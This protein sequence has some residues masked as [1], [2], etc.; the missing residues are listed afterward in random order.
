MAKTCIF[1][2]P[3]LLLCFL[4]PSIGWA[5]PC[6][7][8]LYHLSGTVQYDCTAVTAELDGPLT[9]FSSC[10]PGPYAILPGS[11]YTFTFSPAIPTVR[12]N[13]STINN[14]IL[15]TEEVAFSVN[16]SFY[17]ITVPGVPLAGCGTPALIS[18]T[19]T[20]QACNG[21]LGA[22][23]DIVITEPISTLTIEDILISGAPAGVAVSVYFCCSSCN[24]YAGQML[25][26]PLDV[27]FGNPASLSSSFLPGLESNDILRYILFSDPS[28][29]LGS[30]LATS[31]TPNFPF[32]PATM[33]LGVPYYIAAIAGNNLGGNVDL[34]DPCLDISNAIPVTWHPRPTVEFAVVDPNV[35]AGACTTVTANLTG[36]PPFILTYTT[37]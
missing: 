6:L 16:G 17:P 19:G 9:G 25:D 14:N 27:C 30:I 3:F 28:D 36:T 34:N 21:C 29:T 26:D 1:R 4:A 23:G 2:Q 18:P 35:C 15:G 37:P 20:I 31:I 32:N 13:L 11:S 7:I 24:T 8:Q 5:Q 22:W 10:G 33:T 12:I